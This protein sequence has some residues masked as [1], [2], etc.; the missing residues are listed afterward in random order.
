MGAG[1]VRR[2]VQDGHTAV[3]YDVNPEPVDELAGDSVV[4]THTL[5]EF[6]AA[7][8]T[9][10]VAWVM[11]PAAYAGSTVDGVAEHFERGDIIIDGGNSM[12]QDD[13][14]KAVE[15]AELGIH[16]IDIGTSGGVYGLE[17][18]FSLMVGGEDEAVAHIEPLLNTIAPGVAT[19]ERTLDGDGPLRAGEQGWLHCGPNG[20]GH[21]VKMVHNGIE[22][23]MMAAMAE[24]LGIIAAAGAGLTD[25]VIDAGTT[26]TTSTQPR[27]P[28]CGD[29]DR[30]SA[31]GWSTSPPTRWRSIRS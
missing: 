21:F 9:P 11:V 17:R 14:D 20:A 28:R 8:E 6:A 22:Y 27:S 10:R 29:A 4:A 18:G 5:A 3:A 25:R 15:L 26:N 23:G 31:A 7:L 30:S 1:L 24:G 12:W 19:A 2:I 13:V 16:Y